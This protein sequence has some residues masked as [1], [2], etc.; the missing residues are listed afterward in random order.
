MITRPQIKKPSQSRFGDLFKARSV[1]KTILR[2]DIP[3]ILKEKIKSYGRVVSQP[4]NYDS[5]K[6]NFYIMAHAHYDYTVENEVDSRI[7]L[8]QKTNIDIF[9]VL[10]ELGVE[11][12]FLEGINDQVEMEHDKNYDFKDYPLKSMSV[13]ES[14][15]IIRRANTALEGIY[16][17]DVESVGVEGS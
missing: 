4:E 7:D 2:G 3:Q 10:R 1:D 8:V 5:N 16:G 11:R 12:Q 6:P 9:H 13:Y 14:T 15:G 17:A